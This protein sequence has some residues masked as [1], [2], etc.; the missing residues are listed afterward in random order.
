MSF[1]KRYGYEPS[2]VDILRERISKELLNR[3]WNVIQDKIEHINKANNVNRSNYVIG[4][5]KDTFLEFVLRRC[6]NNFFKDA[7]DNIPKAEIDAYAYF[8][9]KIF[10][11]SWNRFYDFIEFIV[12]LYGGENEI[13]VILELNKVFEEENSAYR[14]VGGYIVEINSQIEIDAIES[15]LK[16]EDDSYEASVHIKDSLKLLSDKGMSDYRNSAKES[17]SAI[18]AMVRKKM[19]STKQLSDLLKDKRLNIHP[20][21]SGAMSK[22]YAYRGDASGV[23]HSLIANSTP[24]SYEDALFILIISSALIN[25]LMLKSIT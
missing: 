6:C 4:S 21:L 1:S 20:C 2:S 15:A 23:G 5:I 9:N 22:L 3:V 7:Y 16:L 11:L 12:P 13:S 18:E 14:F 17:I 19:G 25:L 8:R 10:T 24:V